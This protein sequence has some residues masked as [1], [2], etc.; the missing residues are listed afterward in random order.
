M[1]IIAGY[2]KG[3]KIL[4]PID[5][6]TRPLKDIVRESIFN[7]M[8]HSNLLKFTFAKS[9]ILYDHFSF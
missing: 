1:R 5:K 6:S 7:I 3:R 9:T 8:E 2:L 4:D